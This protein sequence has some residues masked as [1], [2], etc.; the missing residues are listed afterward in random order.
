MYTLW[1]DDDT[2]FTAHERTYSTLKEAKRFAHII[3]GFGQRYY[4]VGKGKLI[5]GKSGTMHSIALHD[6]P[7]PPKAEDW[8]EIP[9]PKPEGPRGHTFSEVSD[10]E[11]GTCWITVRARIYRDDTLV[12][13]ASG[14][15]NAVAMIPKPRAP[16]VWRIVVDPRKD[17]DVPFVY[18]GRSRRSMIRCQT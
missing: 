4:I 10:G 17:S 18:E 5:V 7:E 9:D 13:V 8:P 1:L 16:W 2:H 3:P 11:G 14:K 6:S 12:G 15:V